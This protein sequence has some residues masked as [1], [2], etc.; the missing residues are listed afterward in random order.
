MDIKTKRA[1]RILAV[2]LILMVLCTILSRAAASVLVAQVQV[3]KPDRGK[4]S[5]TGSGEGSVVPV[6]EKLV[7]LWPGQQV[8]WAADAGSTVKAGDCLVQ[9]R[10]EYLQ[11]A[12]EGKQAELTQLELQ[13]QQ[14]QISARGNARVPSADRARQ[15]LADAQRG[16][17][18][19]QQRAAD[20][21]AA[22]DQFQA[23]PVQPQTEELHAAGAS[24]GY[25]ASDGQGAAPAG[26]SMS[27]GQAASAGISMP[28]AQ[29]AAGAS[30][31]IAENMQGTAGNENAAAQNPDSSRQ[32][33][34]ENALGEARAKVE[35][36]QQ[37]V[38]QAQNEYNF[39]MKE[40]AAQ[41][42]NEANAV[43][44][45]Q[46]GAQALN[47]QV[48]TARKA[49]EQLQ[50]YQNAGG[51]ICAEQD[52]TVLESGIQAGIFTTGAEVLVTGSGGWR[53]RGIAS[54]KDR[55][56]LKSGVE[57]EIRLGSGRKQ[58]VK[59]E[60]V[61]VESN[62]GAVGGEDPNATQQLLTCWYA[63]M[64]EH[65]TADS[66]DSFEWTVKAASEKEYEQLIP[67][68][69]LRE[70]TGGAYCLVISEE[71]TMLGT[72]Q[73]ARRVPVTVLEKDSENAAVESTLKDTDQ[74]I[75]T[76]E[77]YV[78]EGDRVRIKP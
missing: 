77:K 48:D 25:P 28:G 65:I 7:F 43:E 67:L 20:A 41:D 51:K 4:L 56:K 63:L 47:V 35:A 40:D 39:A 73:T 60:S 78:Q 37:S 29:T 24:T 66:G 6:Q 19:A 30:S 49:L 71:E 23:A 13:A 11:Q 2:F 53:L 21:Q 5:Y 8:E 50:A 27:G 62:P 68:S 44:S 42:A 72:V 55:E 33:E 54:E 32:Q 69:A 57:A 18:E 16:L 34:L 58:A 75:V 14:Q 17:Q 9:F 45:A 10:M 64:P 74:V 59:I 31:G 12:I 1:V 76:S 26:S 15:A 22:Y 36:A 38:I 52:C 46:L 3:K 61:G 70:E